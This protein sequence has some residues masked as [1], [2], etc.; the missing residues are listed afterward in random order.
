MNAST[1]KQQPLRPVAG[2]AP[3]SDFF[4]DELMTSQPEATR[5]FYR[6]R[7]ITP[8]PREPAAKKSA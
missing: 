7:L 4:Y 6:A 2:E 8:A 5:D 3:G 1:K